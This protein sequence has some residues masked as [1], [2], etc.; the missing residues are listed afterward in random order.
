MVA[1][2]FAWL[3]NY[4]EDFTLLF[5][6]HSTVIS[7]A[8]STALVC[9][10]DWLLVMIDSHN[11]DTLVSNPWVEWSRIYCF[12]LRMET[13][14][15]HALTGHVGDLE[16]KCNANRGFCGRRFGGNGSIWIETAAC[17]CRAQ[18]SDLL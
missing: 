1:S 12:R 10:N 9:L 13:L 16:G 8:F 18:A 11:P 15:R 6:K 7:L 5:Q 4:L 14:V 2:L 3:P 17:G